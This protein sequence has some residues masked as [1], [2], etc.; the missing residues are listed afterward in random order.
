MLL[1]SVKIGSQCISIPEGHQLLQI[2]KTFPTY[3]F[4][5]WN[6]IGEL[7]KVN[8]IFSTPLL[9][10]G[11][12]VGDSV[13][14]FRRISAAHV[15]SV[16]P[17]ARFFEILKVNASLFCEVSLYNSLFCPS[18]LQ[19]NIAYSEGSQTGGTELIQ[20]LESPQS[21]FEFVDFD[22][23]YEQGLNDFILKSDTDGFDSHI[24]MSLCDLLDR[25]DVSVPIVFFEGPTTE[26]MKTGAYH[27][28]IKAIIGLQ[29][30]G[31][32]VLLMSNLGFPV[33]C[34]GSSL[35]EL[36]IAFQGLYVSMQFNR[37]FC[38]YFDIVAMKNGLDISPLLLQG[39]QFEAV[40]SASK[41]F[42]DA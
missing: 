1:T 11:A 4:A 8:N 5:V 23:F 28:F 30:H 25:V 13:A 6:L 35:F 32:D 16:E 17:S 39:E 38:H 33:A 24:I 19:R 29:E 26:Q 3:D 12:N 20:T 41:L 7:I 42:V 2:Y 34:V 15:H 9:D 37:A 18:D 27:D 21:P 22:S 40:Y 36:E 10:I 31:Y 14:H